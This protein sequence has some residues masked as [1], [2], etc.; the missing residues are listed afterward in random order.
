MSKIKNAT[1]AKKIASAI[2]KAKEAF[3]DKCVNGNKI[4]VAMMNH[5]QFVDVA[6][7]ME[8]GVARQIEKI[9]GLPNGGKGVISYLT[10]DE[11][12]LLTVAPIQVDVVDS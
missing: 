12:G 6:E 5:V 11:Q 8:E 4:E 7:L 9:A 1:S 2:K 10:L 3:P